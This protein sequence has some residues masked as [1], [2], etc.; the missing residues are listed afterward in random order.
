LE[1]KFGKLVWLE[2]LW[3]RCWLKYKLGLS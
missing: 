3:N 1:L 2:N